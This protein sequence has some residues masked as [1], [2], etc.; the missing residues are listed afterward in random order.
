MFCI[1][2]LKVLRILANIAHK[3]KEFC[4]QLA[5]L[6]LLSALCATLKMAD[7]DVVTLSL[8]VL[9]MMIISSP[10][11]CN[12]TENNKL[13]ICCN[14]YQC[15]KNTCMCVFFSDSRA[16]CETRWS[17][18]FRS[19]SVQQGRRDEEEGCIPPGAPLPARRNNNFY[20]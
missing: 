12:F 18:T 19:H 15:L 7:Q 11:V 4:L 5:E 10:Q 6:G 8:D 3:S 20:L 9:F 16:V 14:N 1:I 2:F 13:I 17:F